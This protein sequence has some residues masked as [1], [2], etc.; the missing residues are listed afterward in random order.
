MSGVQKPASII[1]ISILKQRFLNKEV[2]L[3]HTGCSLREKQGICREIKDVT[4]YGHDKQKVEFSLAN[5]SSWEFYPDTL[6]ETSVSGNMTT[7]GRRVI[8]IV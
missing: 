8:T 7:K 6:T 4:G 3:T 2:R 5:D 1:D